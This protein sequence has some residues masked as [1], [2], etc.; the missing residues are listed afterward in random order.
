M[1][2]GKE[3]TPERFHKKAGPDRAVAES[4]IGFTDRQRQ[5]AE[6]GE[7]FPDRRTEAELI[8]GLTAAMIGVVGPADKAI[9]TFAQQPLRVAQRKAHLIY[10]ATSGFLTVGCM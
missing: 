7:L 4:A 5:P 2:L 6:I 3:P 9:G 8:A 10:F 1:G